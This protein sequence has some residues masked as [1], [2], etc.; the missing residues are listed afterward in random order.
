MSNQNDGVS[1]ADDPTAF[2][3]HSVTEM[4]SIPRDELEALQL[5]ALQARFTSLRDKVPMLTKLA[6]EQSITQ[7]NTFDDVVPLLF[8]HTIYKSYPSSL[9]E[10][11]RFTQ[12]NKWLNKLSAHDLSSVDV[13]DCKSID[14]W[15]M[16]M[17]TETSLRICHSSGT[18]GT[19]SFLPH[20][21]DEY[22]MLG[23][24]MTMTNLQRFGEP[25]S[26]A[27]VDVIFPN[28]RTGSGSS[29]R[30][31]DL[32][33]KHIS[34]GEERFHAA[35]EGRMSS[36][37]LY[38]AARIRAAQS[39][40][41]L[42]RLQIDD[43]LLA[44]KK[45]FEEVEANM[46][47]HMAA[48]Y[49]EKFEAL[50]GRRVYISCPWNLLHDMAKA[51]LEQG[52]EAMFSSDSIVFTGGGSKGLV[53]PEGWEDDVCR[54][55]GVSSLQMGYGMSEVMAIHPM[56]SHG[57]YHIVPWVIPFVLDP[58]T[59]KVLPRKGKVT[60]RAAFY[61]L[62]ARHAWGGF[63]TGDEITIDWDTPCGCGQTSVHL[64][65]VIQ[66]FT[67]KTGDDDKITCAA[68]ADAQAEAMTFLANFQ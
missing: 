26:E 39:K 7:L 44:R 4:G 56:C 21:E 18:T 16:K 5:K 43:N 35:Y 37:V 50:R 59:S 6:D 38:L 67:D 66:R 55:M 24:A 41:T 12:I 47:T 62:L 27:A 29:L 30:G 32:M 40:G 36:D 31:N 14:D 63:I 58:D 60:G 19:M 15:L 28:F 65:P 25:I 46:P 51:G 34:K 22:D 11:G 57:H 10:K 23:K 61:G 1:L 3:N 54:F 68:T 64:D 42:D 48:F 53:Q 52:Q 33:V 8:E 13:S 45:E 17:E 2:F 20:S 49:S 9:L